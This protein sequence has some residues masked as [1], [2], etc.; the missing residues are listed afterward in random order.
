MGLRVRVRDLVGLIEPGAKIELI[1]DEH[2]DKTVECFGYIPL[3]YLN[4]NV[5]DI[6]SI[7][8]IRGEAVIAL[9]IVTPL[10]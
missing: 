7:T 2:I 5:Y 6:A 4:F 3:I 9:S 1:V 10:C 8:D